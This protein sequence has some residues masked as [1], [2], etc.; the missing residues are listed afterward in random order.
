MCW[1]VTG[2]SKQRDRRRPYDYHL[3]LFVALLGRRLKMRSLNVC[4]HERTCK[5]AGQALL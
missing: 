3:R 2:L 5:Q 4:L 1:G